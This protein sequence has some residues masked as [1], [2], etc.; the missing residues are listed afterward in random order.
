MN[1]LTNYN[2]RVR[3][4][5]T[6][7]ASRIHHWASCGENP[8]LAHFRHFSSLYTNEYRV[9]RIQPRL[10]GISQSSTSSIQYPVSSIQHRVSSIEYPAS[11]IQ[12]RV[13]SIEYP[14][15]SIQNPES[16]IEIRVFYAKQT[17]FAGNPNER[18]FCYNKE[19]RRKSAAQSPQKQTQFKPNQTKLAGGPK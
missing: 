14:A 4:G 6:W 19:L 10:I 11:S 5:R 3:Q 18:N 7:T 15:S 12:H 1:Q 9:S 2:H 16:S 13:S 8:T 17:Q